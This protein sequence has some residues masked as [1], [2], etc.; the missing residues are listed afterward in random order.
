MPSRTRSTTA[1]AGALVVVYPNNPS[2]NPR[3]NPRGAYYENLIISKPVK[4]QGVGP[5]S[6]GRLGARLD[7]RRRRLRRRQPGGDR[8][9]HQDR[10]R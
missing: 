10:Q 3:Q 5:G 7:H 4:L 9:V 2:A 6:P 1:P 8:L